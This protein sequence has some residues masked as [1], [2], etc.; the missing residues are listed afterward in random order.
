MFKHNGV[1]I[2]NDFWVPVIAT[3]NPERVRVALDLHLTRTTVVVVMR[4]GRIVVW[5]LDEPVCD[6]FPVIR[7]GWVHD[8]FCRTDQFVEA[9][10]ESRP[11]IVQ[12]E[13]GVVNAVLE[14]TAIHETKAV[15]VLPSCNRFAWVPMFPAT[16]Q[17]SSHSALSKG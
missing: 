3:D 16:N 15:P 8:A 10:L 7:Q 17:L 4:F 14:L 9:V 2:E 12:I 5:E 11:I 6:P 13:F 1:A